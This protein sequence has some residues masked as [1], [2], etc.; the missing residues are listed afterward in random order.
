MIC[1]CQ[2]LT[3]FRGFGHAFIP[4]INVLQEQHLHDFTFENV[5]IN[6]PVPILSIF[7]VF[8][9]CMALILILKHYDDTPLL[10]RPDVFESKR[11]RE[12]AMSK[13]RVN[14]ENVVLQDSSLHDLKKLFHLFIMRVKDDHIV[15]SLFQR[16][17]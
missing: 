17:C 12:I 13:W 7:I 4:Q 5:F 16:Y 10:A 14:R 15:L 6:Y 8:L 9:F 1:G 11:L 2:H 3:D